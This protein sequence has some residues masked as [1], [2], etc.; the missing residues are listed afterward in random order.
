MWEKLFYGIIFGVFFVTVGSA[1]Q[2]VRV[3]VDDNNKL[4]DFES[5]MLLEDSLC[6]LTLENVVLLNDRFYPATL[7]SRVD[8]PAKCHWAKFTISAEGFQGKSF[9]LE[10][11]DPKTSML[12]FYYQTEHSTYRAIK[13]GSHYPF[14][15]RP[16]QHK[17]FIFQLP[18]LKQS[19]DFLVKI[20]SENRVPFLF[21]IRSF[22]SFS[23][24]A[25]VE[26]FML[27]LFYGTLGI[28]A[29]YNLL[30]FFTVGEKFYL[31]FVLYVLSGIMMSFS[32]DGLGFQFVWPSY[33]V[34]NQCVILYSPL[35]FMVCFCIY[36]ASFLELKV[37]MPA[38]FKTLFWVTIFCVVY[39]FINLQ[40]ISNDWYFPIYIVPFFI[41]F[42]ATAKS[43]L[44]GFKPAQ[45]FLVAF[46][47]VLIGLIITLI[48][49]NVYF[50]WDNIL[51]V[52]ILYIAMLI[53]IVLLSYAQAEKFK[54]IKDAKEKAQEKSINQLKELN[55][56]KDKINEEIEQQVVQ[57]TGEVIAQNK[58]IEQQNNELYQANQKLKTQAE[59]I[60]RINKLLDKENEELK[61]NVKEL[62]KARVFAKEVDFMEFKTIFPDDETCYAYLAK[63]KWENGYACAK[64]NH[65]RFSDGKTSFSKRCSKCGYTESATTGTLFYRVHFPILKGFYMLFLV[66]ANNGKI[67]S[68]ELSR[69]LDLRQNTCW[70]FS[71]KIK[72]KLNSGKS[73]KPNHTEQKGWASLIL[74]S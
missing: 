37:R 41:I 34:F 66:Y 9:L 26:Y 32:E 20:K 2:V 55:V 18:E 39:Y 23:G 57:K 65:T 59:E 54:F 38:V 42:Y 14:H 27:G 3:Q 45:I 43:S 15:L 4:I 50:A 73:K 48:R 62:S 68:A 31:Y 72:E 53:E 70:K 46:S 52:Y 61:F 51:F 11:L 33:P 12:D 13:L 17:N 6:A 29:I 28:M 8:D 24:Y 1:Q 19:T 21:K 40:F 60:A 10:V 58:I 5:I 63:L 36:A 35:L 67:T 30:L 16:F 49:R 71:K 44:E 74:N 64:C 47:L 69:I 7:S 25:V 22:K 56:I